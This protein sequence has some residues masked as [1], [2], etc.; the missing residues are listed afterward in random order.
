MLQP[1]TSPSPIDGCLPVWTPM[2]GPFSCGLSIGPLFGPSATMLARATPASVSEGSPAP[3][4][5]LNPPPP[6]P[7]LLPCVVFSSAGMVLF[8]PSPEG[9]PGSS[10]RGPVAANTPFSSG[11]GGPMTRKR[12]RSGSARSPVRAA[13]AAAPPLLCN[14]WPHPLSA[15]PS[16][17]PKR[18]E[19][20]QRHICRE[21]GRGKD[22]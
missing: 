12:T 13:A 3:L 22:R 7:A 4:L 11:S 6:P 1:P 16:N 8:T 10:R 19:R 2:E 17:G 18:R 5:L 14:P 21:G 20:E 9:G 15:A